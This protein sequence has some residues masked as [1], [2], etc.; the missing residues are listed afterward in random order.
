VDVSPGAG[1]T[2]DVTL[3]LSG[4]ATAL[5]RASVAPVVVTGGSGTATVT[6]TTTAR[7][8]AGSY[9]LTV[10]AE[11]AGVV[12]TADAT[13]RVVAPARLTFSTRGND[14]P[15]GVVGRA[16]DADLYS[17]NGA[18]Y[19]RAW[20]ASRAGLGGTVDIDGLDVVDGNDF[21][22]STSAAARIP[23][24]GTVQDEDVLHY[25]HGSWSVFFDGTAHGLRS[26]SLDVDAIS[27][28]GR[29][30]FFST[31]GRRNP[32]GVRGTADDADVYAWNGK[33]IRRVWDASA[34]RV[35]RR[36]A[37]DGYTRID[38]RHFYLSFRTAN[39][40]LPGLGTVQDEDVVYYDDGTW[41]VA[42]DGTAHGLRSAGL[43]IDAFDVG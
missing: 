43:D 32:P 25:A 38:A 14:D 42:F 20:D 21:Y 40:R 39:V 30:L 23:G 33:R 12:R 35:P 7:A 18:A 29:T 9:P 24:L 27:I 11:G 8:R 41:S 17:W 16:D 13:L 22:V 28:S 26:A 6:V 15:P 10:T 34:H 5:G 37:V 19:A 2:G 31:H 4:S 3:A 1:F 36:A